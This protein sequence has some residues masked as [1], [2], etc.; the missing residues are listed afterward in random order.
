MKDTAYQSLASVAT[1]LQ[2]SPTAF[3]IQA[4]SGVAPTSQ[5]LTIINRGDLDLDL[6]VA[7][8]ASSTRVTVL[9]GQQAVVTCAY[10]AITATGVTTLTR[11]V[12]T[13][14]TVTPSLAAFDT[15]VNVT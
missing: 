10:A 11:N 13:H 4:A 7:N 14:G 5:T 8:Y 3:N 9:A 6:D 2:L 15:V 1:L 12:Y